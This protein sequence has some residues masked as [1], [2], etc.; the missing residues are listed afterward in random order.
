MDAQ[1]RALLDAGTAQGLTLADV[2]GRVATFDNLHNEADP[3][4]V[5]GNFPFLDN[6]G[7][8]WEYANA[9]LGN[10]TLTMTYETAWNRC[11]HAAQLAKSSYFGAGLFAT[12]LMTL[13]R[14]MQ[15]DSVVTGNLTRFGTKSKLLL[16]TARI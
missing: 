10:G 2:L 1:I 11:W 8:D 12:Y 3:G 16:G 6:S 13:V 15:R 4:W 7:V 9:L 5:T 14:I